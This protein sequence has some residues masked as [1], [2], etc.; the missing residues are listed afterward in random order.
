MRASRLVSMMLLLQA[1]GRMT[2]E[3]LAAELEVSVR[4]IYRDV[5][6]LHSSGVPLYGE[7]GHE[8]GYRLLDGYRTRLT[9]LT[10]DEAAALALSGLPGPAAELG[11]SVAAGSA[12]MKIRAA[13]SDDQRERADHVDRRLHV[14]S[15]NWYADPLETPF[16][17]E[18]ADAVWQQR[19]L[20]VR[21]R[22]WQAPREVD[23]TLEPFGLV[24]KAGR[25]YL[26]ARSDQRLRTYRVSHLLQVELLEDGFDRPAD[27]D[28]AA[29]WRD[30]M[31][32][33]DSRRHVEE[34][35]MR[36]SPRAQERFADLAEPAVAR[37]VAQSAGEPDGEGWVSATFPIE[38]IDHAHDELLRFGADIEV[39]TP[40]ALRERLTR[41][42]T[43]L[44]RRYRAD[45]D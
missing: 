24:L 1:R 14:D 11:L 20:Q 32:D 23:R 13:L 17:A 15:R 43:Q 8:G 16:L 36:L 21:Y 41:T 25:W 7:P 22:R 26:V 3:A 19:R 34:A 6:A 35:T 18:V 2:A 38:S 12:A 5:E 40:P 27:F 39:L 45:P 33:F 9:G 4:T 42:A 44:A 29:H 28:L 30:A 10:T 37:A 31:A